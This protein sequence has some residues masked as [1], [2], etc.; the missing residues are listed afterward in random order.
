MTKKSRRTPRDLMTPA[1]L[2]ILLALAGEDRHG[3]GI[4]RDVEERTGGRLRLGPGTLYEAVH[5][6]E[7][8]GWIREVEGP[9]G[10]AGKR[11]Y[12][13]L[14]PEGRRRMEEELRRLDR[15]VSFARREALLST[16]EAT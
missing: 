8:D 7:D 1:A 15:I 4:K 5:R 14:A 9:E 13:R 3:Y 2:H 11:K 6:M 12:Y 16:E 10:G